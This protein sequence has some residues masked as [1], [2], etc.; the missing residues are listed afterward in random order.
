MIYPRRTWRYCRALEDAV[1]QER[2]KIMHDQID[3]DDMWYGR[4]LYASTTTRSSL[5]YIDNSQV[6]EI[7][8]PEIQGF[9]GSAC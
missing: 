2:S 5:S 4:S 9:A 1:M 7:Q 8:G 6:V 3:M